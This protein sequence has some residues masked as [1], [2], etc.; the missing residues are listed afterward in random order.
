MSRRVRRPSRRLARLVLVEVAEAGHL[1]CEETGEGL[2]NEYSH[3]ETASVGEVSVDGV[4]PEI[5]TDTPDSSHRSLC[6]T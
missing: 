5:R 3:A 2:A 4:L 1:H 6:Y